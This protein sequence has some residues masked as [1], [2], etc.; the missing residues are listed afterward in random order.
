M[1]DSIP[2]V[3]RS[4]ACNDNGLAAV[5]GGR[6]VA[7]SGILTAAVKVCEMVLLSYVAQ[8]SMIVMRADRRR[9]ATAA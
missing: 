7:P 4:T 3:T 1:F 8:G 5:L 6:A 9:I 2:K